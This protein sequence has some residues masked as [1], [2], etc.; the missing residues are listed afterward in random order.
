MIRKTLALAAFITITIAN[1]TAAQPVVPKVQP[2]A[3]AI[4]PNILINQRAQFGQVQKEIDKMLLE[5]GLDPNR[6][7]QINQLQ[8]EMDKIFKDV[9]LDPKGKAQMDQLQKEIDKIFKDAGV[10]PNFR[11]PFDQIQRDL[12]R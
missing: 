1:F 7:M 3:P 2:K 11:N 5:A 8:K 12:D 4:N 10:D 6:K 9:G